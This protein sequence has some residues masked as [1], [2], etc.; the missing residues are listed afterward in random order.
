MSA[1]LVVAEINLFLTLDL[2]DWMDQQKRERERGRER[3]GV[4]TISSMALTTAVA[5]GCRQNSL[6]ATIKQQLEPER[7]TVCIGGNK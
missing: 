5:L 6:T 7:L 3:T 1:V 4:Y 2:T